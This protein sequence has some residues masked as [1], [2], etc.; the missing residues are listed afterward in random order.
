MKTRLNRRG[1]SVFGTTSPIDLAC[2]RISC[3]PRRTGEERWVA[4]AGAPK[5]T[6][7]R[8]S[9]PSP[10]AW[11]AV[12]RGHRRL[13]GGGWRAVNRDVPVSSMRSSRSTRRSPMTSFFVTSSVTPR[14]VTIDSRAMRLS[15]HQ[16]GW[17]P[18]SNTRRASLSMR[19]DRLENH[20]RD[21]RVAY[22]P[23]GYG[24]ASGVGPGGSNGLDRVHGLFTRRSRRCFR[25]RLH[26]CRDSSHWS[27][28][29]CLWTWT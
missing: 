28:L 18:A 14:G 22:R 25:L 3:V 5:T 24:A 27:R 21:R 19:L 1:R 6:G 20:G 16:R 23:S 13:S 8:R 11:R 17:R 29:S 4:V 9:A 2:S 15:R 7:R 10:R 12:W 26:G